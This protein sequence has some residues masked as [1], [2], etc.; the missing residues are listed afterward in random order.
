[1]V[2]EKSAQMKLVLEKVLNHCN[3]GG[4]VC[5]EFP[6]MLK[7]VEKAAS[8]VPAD[9]A[10]IVAP[11]KKVLE[12]IINHCS[13]GVLTRESRILKDISVALFTFAAAEVA[14]VKAAA[15][16]TATTAL[17]VYLRSCNL[18]SCELDELTYHEESAHPEV[19]DLRVY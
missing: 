16:A 8:D 14:T 1:M 19:N 10:T 11:L 6:G 7:E 4:I 9:Q 15:A 18:K 17:A 2:M 13:W 5:R 3:W 12:Q